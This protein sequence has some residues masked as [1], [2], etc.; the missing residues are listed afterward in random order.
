MLSNGGITVVHYIVSGSSGDGMVLDV[1]AS[2]ASRTA[3]SN[4]LNFFV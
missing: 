2:A 3:A 4:S 1:G